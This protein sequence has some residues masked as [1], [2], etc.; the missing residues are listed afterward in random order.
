MHITSSQVEELIESR[1]QDTGLSKFV[2]RDYSQFLDVAEELFVE[3]VLNDGTA[4]EDVEK[5]V[6]H[7]AQ[8][9]KTQ[10]VRLDSVV[11]AI[12]EVG[13]VDYIGPARGSSGGL[14]AAYEF[15]VTLK[16]GERSHQVSV[17]V[18][19]GAMEFLEHK[20]GLKKFVA[21]HDDALRQ[22]H[23]DEVIV[24]NL[25]RSFVQYELSRGGTS[26]WNPLLDGRLDLNDTAMAFFLGQSTAF[27]ELRQAISDAFEPA[28]V[29]SF[30]ASL[31][32]SRVRIRDFGAVLPE[33]SNMLGGAYRRGETFSTS[34]SEL[35]QKMDRTE[36][37][38]LK[39]YF[40]GKVE[41][42]KSESPELVRHFPEVFS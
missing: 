8:E 29:E 20:L 3:I 25:V 12:W 26:Y 22:G 16:S 10:G 38:L 34:A 2:N 4:L 24:G 15:R 19:W 36:Q 17:D 35:F 32:V 28:V 7:T 11:R 33:L 18:S 40:Y 6:R 23:L 31:A 27:N 21:G 30:L 14:R 9:L 5:I 42:L 39:K 13:K 37:E 41:V 1:L